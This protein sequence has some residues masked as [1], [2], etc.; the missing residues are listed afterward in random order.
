VS[1]LLGRDGELPRSVQ[2]V[3]SLSDWQPWIEPAAG[4][5]SFWSHVPWAWAYRIPVF[6][7]YL[8]LLAV[9]TIWP[10]PKNLAHLLALSAALLIGIQFWYAEQG[11]VYVL[12]YLPL[13]LLL[14]FRPNLAD[15]RP[16]PIN[17][18]TDWLLRLGEFL[19]RLLRWPLAVLLPD[20][21]QGV[22]G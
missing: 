11:G 22:R 3:L 7:A 10:H 4:S 12:W 16:L 14:V 5:E 15:R 21:G 19:V 17:R 2:T 20:G 18:D 9:T 1:L 6:V 8:A 13:L